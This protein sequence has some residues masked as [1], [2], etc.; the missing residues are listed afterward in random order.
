MARWGKDSTYSSTSRT[1]K[2]FDK[3]TGGLPTNAAVSNRINREATPPNEWQFYELEL[4]EVMVVYD[5]EDKLPLDPSGN[6]D[7]TLWGAIKARNH[8][9]DNLKPIDELD[10]FYPIDPNHTKLPLRNELVVTSK[11]KETHFY[12]CINLYPQS[13]NAGIRP[14]TSGTQTDKNKSENFLYENIEV[15]SRFGFDEN[16]RQIKPYEGDITL[17]GRFGNTIRFGSNIIPNSF[18]DGD[19]PQNSPNI[20]IRAGQREDIGQGFLQP[21]EEDINE[22]AS[23]IWIVSDQ[24]VMLDI[25]NTNATDHRYMTSEQGDDQPNR[26]GKQITIN[27]DRITWNS[28]D[29]RLLGFASK[30]IGFSTQ[31]SFSVDSDNGVQM[32]SGGS[33]NM[34]MVPG[35][36][37]LITPGNSRLDL[38][39]GGEGGGSDTIYLSSECPSFLTLD[40]KAHLE[41]CKGANV[42][43][44]DCAGLYTDNGSYFKIGGSKDEAVIYVKGRDDVKEQ[45]L[46]F[47]EK[48]TEILDL[49]LA[50]QE[51][52]IDTVMSFSAIA[53]GAGPSGPISSGP[54]NQAL[55]DAFKQTQ[56][57]VIRA[58]ICDILT[59]VD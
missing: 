58:Q 5:T 30:G 25:S 19:S 56:V 47:G 40:D 34:S 41:S 45:H 36:I 20:L 17:Q 54:P 6:P 48:L 21:V 2:Q 44:D 12:Q 3:S 49:M 24:K 43:L 42:H 33:T 57:E 15:N 52:L 8:V 35:G 29:G 22:D 18:E 31:G 26:G 59:R 1:K 10:I 39:Q 38:G 4:A 7:Y 14:G 11:Y 50:S 9:S 51:A 53:T 23:S 13:V 32:N 27:S 37:S 28:K 46:V 16:V 55:V